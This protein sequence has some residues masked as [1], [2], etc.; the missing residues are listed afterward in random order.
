MQK[1]KVADIKIK[2]GTGEKGDWTNTTI[3]DDKG[4]RFSSFDKKLSKLNKGAL[5][6]AEI[7]ID[8][9]YNNI[10]EWKLLEEGTVPV[11]STVPQMNKEDWAKKDAIQSLSIEA[12]TAV[13]ALL[14]LAS[15]CPVEEGLAHTAVEKALKWCIDRIDRTMV[16][17]PVT[18][19]KTT[20]V[21]DEKV[22]DDSPVK[23]AGDLLTR[24]QKIGVTRARILELEGVSDINQIADL[25]AAWGDAQADVWLEK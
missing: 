3:I 14:L 16:P 18:K 1:I 2:T 7:V 20:K 9:K 22:K 17:A 24:C 5:I 6:E 15:S 19:T 25:D 13:K 12:Q 10:K 8:G 23:D 21:K 4:G 11:A